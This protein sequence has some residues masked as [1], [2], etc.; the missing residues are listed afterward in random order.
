MSTHAVWRHSTVVCV[1]WVTSWLEP[2]A[3]QQR[4]TTASYNSC[5]ML[6]LC[7]ALHTISHNITKHLLIQ[8]ECQCERYICK[9]RLDY[10]ITP[11]CWLDHNSVTEREWKVLTSTWQGDYLPHAVLGHPFF[12]VTEKMPP[13]R[14]FVVELNR[15]H[16]KVRFPCVTS[17]WNVMQIL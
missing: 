10:I 7:L 13:T 5:S 12:I 2:V 3:R 1:C 17:E 9:V 4:E 6:V 11:L 8:H 15:K 16:S 14:E